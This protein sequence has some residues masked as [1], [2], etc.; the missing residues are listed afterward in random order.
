MKQVVDLEK[1]LNLLIFERQEGDK[2]RGLVTSS[3]AN[4]LS[5][6]SELVKSNAYKERSIVLS[7][8]GLHLVG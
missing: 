6:T 3:A 1:E 8:R 7:N 2:R 4:L 5:T